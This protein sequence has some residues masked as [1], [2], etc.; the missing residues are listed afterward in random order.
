MSKNKI[1]FLSIIVPERIKPVHKIGRIRLFKGE[2]ESD[3]CVY[4]LV[5]KSKEVVY[6]GQTYNLFNRLAT[7]RNDK[8]F[9]KVYFLT[10]PTSVKKNKSKKDW[11]NEKEKEYIQNYLPIYN[12]CH[13]RQKEMKR[14]TDIVEAFHF[15]DTEGIFDK[16][17]LSDIR[18]Q[19]PSFF[20][21]PSALSR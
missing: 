21:R 11:I 9:D 3:R 20:D 6:V 10:E 2:F 5:N 17:K 18:E 19:V 13:V 4:F 15:F 14:L 1:D 12:K 16:L 8:D 7:H